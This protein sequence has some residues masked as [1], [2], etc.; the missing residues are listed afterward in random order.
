M[1]WWQK[2]S[3]LFCYELQE[4]QEGDT[5]AHIHIRLFVCFCCPLDVLKY[6]MN[7]GLHPL[8]KKLSQD[9]SSVLS[10]RSWVLSCPTCLAE[11]RNSPSSSRT[12]PRRHRTACLSSS[13]SPD[14][15]NG[16]MFNYTDATSMSVSVFQELVL[17]L[18]WKLFSYLLLLYFANVN[19]KANSWLYCWMI[20]R[21][22][23]V[24]PLNKSLQVIIP[25][26]Q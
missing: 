25:W 26:E 3:P 17:V 23:K 20:N 15:S 13:L 6:K 12:G 19:I 10:S 7:L 22:R 21:D 14:S 1:F 11:L 5:S 9:R 8:S 18:S 24:M 2:R 16:S 4:H